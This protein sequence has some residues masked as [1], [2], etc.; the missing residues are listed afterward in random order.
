MRKEEQA[1]SK[2][3]NLRIQEVEKKKERTKKE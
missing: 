3:N 2:D 1:Y